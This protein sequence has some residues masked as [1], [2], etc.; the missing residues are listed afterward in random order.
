MNVSCANYIKLNDDGNIHTQRYIKI[1]LKK[2]LVHA[3]I[4]IF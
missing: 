3:A 1:S 4:N 2:S